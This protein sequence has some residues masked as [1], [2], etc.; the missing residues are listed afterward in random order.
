MQSSEFKYNKQLFTEKARKWT[1]EHAVQKNK[2]SPSGVW[3]WKQFSTF[4]YFNLIIFWP[5]WVGCTALTEWHG[6]CSLLQ[7]TIMSFLVLAV[8]NCI[9]YP[10]GGAVLYQLN[11]S[12][13]HFLQSDTAY[14]ICTH[15]WPLYY[16]SFLVVEDHRWAMLPLS[17]I[18][19]VFVQGVV[20]SNKENTPDQKASSRKRETCGVQQEAEEPAKRTCM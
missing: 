3:W 14:C 18:I 7:S 9:F 19:S 13:I 20:E 11:V 15:M 8:C 17:K 10:Q 6:Y 4:K 5:F 16:I 12:S 2:V 1:Q